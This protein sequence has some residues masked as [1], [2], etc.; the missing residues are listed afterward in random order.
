MRQQRGPEGL[1]HATLQGKYK[2]TGDCSRCGAS[3]DR[4][5]AAR[6]SPSPSSAGAAAR[7]GAERLCSCGGSAEQGVRRPVRAGEPSP[8]S[9]HRLTESK[10]P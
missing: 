2:E 1:A 10:P 3:A 4:R 8:H 7:R 5:R 6:N 9:P